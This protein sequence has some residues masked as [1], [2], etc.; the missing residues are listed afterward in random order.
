MARD[1]SQQANTSLQ[2]M[3]CILERWAVIRTEQEA[4]SNVQFEK[5]L[6]SKQCM[7]YLAY[8]PLAKGITKEA[9]ILHT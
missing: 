1:C 6:A 9:K 3:F 7:V 5:W 2:F 4:D 8:V